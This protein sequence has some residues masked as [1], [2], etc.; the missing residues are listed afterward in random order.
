M[1]NQ[2]LSKAMQGNQNAKKNNFSNV[3]S[4]ASSTNKYKLNPGFTDDLKTIG[5]NSLEL[6]KLKSHSFL[7]D[8]KKNAAP[9]KEFYKD[10]EFAIKGAALGA[11]AGAATG[12][13]YPVT[14]RAIVNNP[15]KA[16]AIAAA[17][18]VALAIRDR[19][20]PKGYRA[21]SAY[22]NA[23]NT[24]ITAGTAALLRKAP[25]AVTI[26]IFTAVGAVSGGLLGY[27]ADRYKEHHGLKNWEEVKKHIERSK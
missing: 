8:I 14:G 9:V 6:T 21:K 27:G 25:I 18:N 20:E 5:Q 24:G 7:K 17:Y 12:A 19:D 11:V 15:G 23:M 2:N 22:Y 13:L 1:K 26:P 3:T 16:T 4:D 10:N